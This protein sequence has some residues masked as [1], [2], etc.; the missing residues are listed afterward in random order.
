MYTKVPESLISKV[1]CK[2]VAGNTDRT[3]PSAITAADAAAGQVH[4][5]ENMPFHIP[6][7][8]GLNLN[9]LRLVHL[10]KTTSAVTQRTSLATGVAL[11]TL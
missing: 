8:I 6:I 11:Y 9:P 7:C 5:T 2:E 1:H 3:C 4:G 10:N